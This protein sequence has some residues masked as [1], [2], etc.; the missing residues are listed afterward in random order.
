YD[1]QEGDLDEV[2]S[3]DFDPATRTVTIETFRDVSYTFT[4]SSGKAVTRGV[5][6]EGRK[7]IIRSESYKADTYVLTLSRGGQIKVLELILGK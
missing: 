1:A 7:I 4:D 3:L 2:S 5:S 6:K